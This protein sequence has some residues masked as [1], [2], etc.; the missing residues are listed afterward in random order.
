MKDVRDNPFSFLDDWYGRLDDI[1]EDLKN[2]GFDVLN[3]TNEFIDV[4]DENDKEYVLKLG[5]TERTITINKIEALDESI[6]SLNEGGIYPVDLDNDAIDA[7]EDKL[8]QIL[9]GYVS[10]KNLELIPAYGF[11]GAGVYW[12]KCD[13]DLGDDVIE[14]LLD[15]KSTPEAYKANENNDLIIYMPSISVN[16]SHD[17][18]YEVYV[19]LD[20]RNESDDYDKLKNEEN[21]ISAKIINILKENEN[22]LVELLKEYEIFDESLIPIKEWHDED[23]WDD[24]E[25]ASIYGGDSKDSQK[26]IADEMKELYLDEASH[27]KLGKRVKSLKGWKI[28]QGTDDDGN[29]IFRCFTPDDD[30]PTIGYEDW[31]T[32]TLEQAISWIENYDLE[33]SLI[34]INEFNKEIVKEGSEGESNDSENVTIVIERKTFG[35]YEKNVFNS[36]DN[37]EFL[38]SSYKELNKDTLKVL[39]S[40]LEEEL[41]VLKDINMKLITGIKQI[42]L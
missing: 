37:I 39:I 23:E 36:L 13:I 11:G 2:N 25:L 41:E 8:S 27:P 26:A 30:R 31:E 19:D 7:F 21:I 33:E 1:I 22:D 10:V 9:N 40:S 6:K 4:S 14:K 18:E 28:Y 3:A 16:C 35:D 12:Y 38:A 34:P 29:E 17:N 32:E 15:S 24:D 42:T 20:S 5:G